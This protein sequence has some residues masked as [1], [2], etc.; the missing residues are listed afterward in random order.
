MWTFVEF[1]I[2][3]GC[4]GY[5]VSVPA[6]FDKVLKIQQTIEVGLMNVAIMVL[7]NYIPVI[8]IF[9]FP[10][11]YVVNQMVRASQLEDVKSLKKHE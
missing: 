7:C 9:E 6:T 11:L 10:A 2:L 1:V 8:W 5:S 3:I 4:I